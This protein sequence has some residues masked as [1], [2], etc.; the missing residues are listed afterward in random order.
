M[1]AIPAR[2]KWGEEKKNLIIE[3]PWLKVLSYETFTYWSK[4]KLPNKDLTRIYI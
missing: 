2:A 3:K 1:K 4:D